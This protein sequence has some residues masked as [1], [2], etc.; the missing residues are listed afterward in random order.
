[1]CLRKPGRQFLIYYQLSSRNED[2]KLGRPWGV[3]VVPARIDCM[4]GV[5]IIAPYIENVI[6]SKVSMRA[7]QNK[8]QKIKLI[9]QL[10]G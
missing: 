7:R 5:E 3:L 4:A 1:M 2:A 10:K 6:R 9:T 8:M